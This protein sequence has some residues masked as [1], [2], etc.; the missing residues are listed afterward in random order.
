MSETFTALVLD[1][2]DD[3]FSAEL[4]ALTDADLPEGDV[5]VAVE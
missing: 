1:Q 2:S 4:R 5:T 3:N